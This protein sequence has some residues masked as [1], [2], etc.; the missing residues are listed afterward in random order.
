M[1]VTTATATKDEFGLP[2]HLDRDRFPVDEWALREEVFG[3]EDQGVTES[4]FSVGNGYLGMR[5]NVEEG[6]DSFSHGTFINGFHETWD[7]RHAEEAYGFART[8]Q[9]IV[10]VPDAKILRLYVD[11][12]PLLLPVADL[13]S[14]ERTLDFRDGVLTRSL[15]WRTPAGKHVRIKSRRM[16]S[17]TDRHLAIMTYE[18]T[19]LDSD[20]PVAISSQILNRQ[21]GGD[22]Y[23]VRSE[24][25]GS[26]LDPR[27]AERLTERVLQPRIQWA[28]EGRYVLGYRCMNS[29]M[30]LAVAADHTID[31]ENEVE[32]R[33][34]VEEDLAK[35]VYRVRARK[36]Q[37]IRITKVVSY[38]TSRG[39]PAREL[40][41]RC[42]RTLDR[43]KDDGIDAYLDAQR[44]WLSDYWRRCDV[45][46][47][48][49]P[50]AQQAVRWNL[51]QLAQATARA[52]GS[53]IPAKGVTG[54]GYGGHYFWDSELYILPYLTY[55]TPYAARNALRFRYTMLPA[56]RARA[57]ELNTEGAL[58]PWRTINGEEAS[59]YY[60]A[61]TAQ[62]HI[63]ADIA[64]ALHQ[65]LNATG[66]TDFLAREAIDL[67]V[68]TARM[69]ADLGFRRRNGDG[70]TFHIHGVTGP[71]E[72]TTVVNDNLYTN[73]MARFNLRAAASAV[74]WLSESDPAAHR[75][76]VKRLGLREEE[77]PA[78]LLAAEEMYI[79]FDEQ[80]GIHP[81]D[82]EFLEKELWDLDNTP[83]HK[84]PLLL[85]YHPLVIYRYQVL[86]QADVVL[87]LFLQGHEFTAEEKRKDFDYY[88][89]LTTGDSTLSAVS[90]AVVAAE[91]GYQDLAVDYFGQALY[92]DLANL[93]HNSAEG[94]HVASAAGVWGVLVF[95][96]GGMRDRNGTISLDPRL[97]E[98][99]EGLTYR[100]TLRS[101]RVRVDLYR[102]ELTLTVEEGESAELD[103][104]GQSVTVTATAPVTV[105]LEN[106]GPRLSGAPTI[107]DI[108][109]IRR[110]DGTLVTATV[111]DARAD[112]AIPED[113]QPDEVPD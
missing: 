56:A 106:Q 36:G 67:L 26:G 40:V 66:D 1:T 18:V 82:S 62:Y 32:E 53:G 102:R 49:Q 16:T 60:A 84:R 46:L 70:G 61:G 50:A 103:V 99:W 44:R 29:G 63:D 55:T 110:A 37:P 76:V 13:H 77:V 9:T 108:K 95:G 87:A 51:F 79:P 83:R 74:Q 59:A 97:P 65:Y 112:G 17:L 5:G 86:K 92:V 68:G 111:P 73:V 57:K 52:E 94:V 14:Y 58:F 98:R 72:Y 41:D 38:H 64:Y 22:E 78:W 15:D 24:A 6:R 11:D 91:V 4:L 42:R 85:F 21:D 39:V 43:V 28:G 2:T 89:P 80:I 47:H 96:F 23:D 45:V 93:H 19:V 101:T 33:S 109:G 71:D 27:R 107:E 75:A 35:H 113:L 54:S 100:I 8:G 105:A 90:Q 25:L 3:A 88:D 7:I 34:Q 31:T 48:G 30:T 20:A 81:Q 69:W 104:R 12:E 10:N